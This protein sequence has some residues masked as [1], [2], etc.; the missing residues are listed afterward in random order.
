[1]STPHDPGSGDTPQDP[2]DPQNPYGT[3][4]A[5]PPPPPPPSAAPSEQ[6]PYGQPTYG[7]P[8]ATPIPPAAPVYGTEPTGAPPYGEPTYDQPAYGQPQPAQPAYGQPPFPATPTNEP[9]K[10]MAI[11]ALIL[12]FFG[13]VILGALIAIPLAI[14]V[15]VRSARDG[16]NH[17]KG[18][19]IS[20]IVISV[21][22]LALP[23]ILIA[24]G[25][26]Y[27]GSL[28]DVNDLEPGDCITATGLTDPNADSVT[29]IK[30]VSCSDAH[31]GEVLATVELTADQAA[32]Y[33]ST[34][35]N[36]I[37]DPA[38]AAEGKTD[39]LS[40]TVTYTALTV[41]DPEAGDTA[42]CVAYHADGSDLTSRLGS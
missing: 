12:S 40:D 31:D 28:T 22:T 11:A 33:A 1:M 24:V 34:P 23:V 26:T 20:A 3:P 10:G 19:A 2:T 18:L 8:P 41:A 25:V 21:L 14:V 5:P 36:T 17:G 4:P 7:Q 6:P 35:F 39:L 30:T 27:L 32:N 42:A 13:C 29:D 16:R 9:G 15:L 37:C 38:I